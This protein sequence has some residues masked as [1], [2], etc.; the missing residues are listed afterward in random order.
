MGF[1]C[2]LYADLIGHWQ[3]RNGE[4]LDFTDPAN[5]DVGLLQELA[6]RYGGPEMREAL[7]AGKG[8]STNNGTGTTGGLTELDD[9]AAC[10]I[11]TAS[12]IKSLFIDPFYFGCE[13][14]DAT[15]AWAF[16]TKNNPFDAEL[17]TLF[18]SD[19]GHFD[20]Q[21][22]AGVLP[23]AY[24]LVEDAK[25][26]PDHF[27]HFVFENPVK[28]WGETN[29]GFFDGTRVGQAASTLLGK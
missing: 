29:P 17:K 15:N 8:I 10:E 26:T 7:K 19:V 9:Y 18:G 3:I 6:D 13:A 22:M 11:K 2:L 25:I 16:N 12:D 28:F 5:L 23:E 24:E 21:D 20:V 4:A 14:D 1:A 27:R